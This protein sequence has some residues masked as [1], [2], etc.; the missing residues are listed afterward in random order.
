MSA[1]IKTVGIDVSKN[2][3]DIGT[4]PATEDFR[5]RYDEEGL[6]KLVLKLTVWAPKLVVFE[7]TGGYE[8]ELG[9]ALQEAGLPF[10]MI[11]P[12]QGR[13]FARATGRLAK[14]DSID[15]ELLAFYGDA[16]KLEPRPMREEDRR[17]LSELVTRRRQLKKARTAESNRLKQARAPFVQR[18]IKRSLKTIEQDIK[19]LEQEIEAHI[20]KNEALQASREILE[21]VPGVGLITSATLISE[22]PELGTLNRKEVAK[23]IGVAPINRDSGKF[24]G[25]RKTGGG[26]E[27]VRTVL[28]MAA[29]TATRYS[30]EFQSFYQRLIARGKKARVALVAVIRKLITVLNAMMRD[31]K[32]WEPSLILPVE[33]T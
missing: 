2:H 33:T 22:V 21:S 28:Y 14:T 17:I 23:L 19:R 24:R 26:R 3:L 4:Y 7:A 11:N 15:A 25:T 16:V 8:L 13:D 9:W 31:N 5:V 30:P 10:A 27:K 12:R 6:A 18:S 32:K 29:L 20:K 1:Q